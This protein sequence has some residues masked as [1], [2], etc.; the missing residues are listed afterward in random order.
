[1]HLHHI[2]PWL[3]RQPLQ[4]LEPSTLRNISVD[5]LLLGN[6]G[7]V[8]TPVG[9]SLLQERTDALALVTSPEGIVIQATLEFV[10]PAKIVGYTPTLALFVCTV[11]GNGQRDIE[12]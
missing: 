8:S 12:S 10:V 1:M 4:T 11:P 2:P 9:S 3:A 6:S 7:C 5:L